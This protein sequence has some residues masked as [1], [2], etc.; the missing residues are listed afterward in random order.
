MRRKYNYFLDTQKIEEFALQYLQCEEK[1]LKET[2]DEDTKK[3]S[4]ADKN[5][6]MKYLDYRF[7][8]IFNDFYKYQDN[9]FFQKEKNRAFTE[10]QKIA[11]IIE[12]DGLI[13]KLDG[14]IEKVGIL[15]GINGEHY[16]GDHIKPHS[17][18]GSTDMS[19]LQ[20]LPKEDNLKKSDS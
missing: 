16:H 5:R 14:T 20:L 15:Q 9:F 17:K 1:R 7:H 4:W 3:S 11:K 13:E 19:N 2:F 8:Q 12:T 10:G 6:N 18:G